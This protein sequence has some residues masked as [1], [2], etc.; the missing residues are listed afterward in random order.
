MIEA[1]SRSRLLYSGDH[2]TL[3]MEALLLLRFETLSRLKKSDYFALWKEAL[4][5]LQIDQEIFLKF[6]LKGV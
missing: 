5:L 3:W 4:L 2:S 6:V 1:T